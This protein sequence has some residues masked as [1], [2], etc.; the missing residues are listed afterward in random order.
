MQE[1]E[2]RSQAKVFLHALAEGLADKNEAN[3]REIYATFN[4]I[5]EAAGNDSLLTYLGQVLCQENTV[6]SIKQYVLEYILQSEAFVSKVE[7]GK[8]DGK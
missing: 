1:K 5:A 3:R 4:K 8:L 7:E 2:A 6:S